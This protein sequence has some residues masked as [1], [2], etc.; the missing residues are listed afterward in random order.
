M[1]EILC[2]VCAKAETAAPY[3]GMRLPFDNWNKKQ[4][5]EFSA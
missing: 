3:Q 5:A 2:S 4:N 1:W